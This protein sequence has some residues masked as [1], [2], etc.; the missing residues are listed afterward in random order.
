M[1]AVIQRVSEA[2]V[3]V[4]GEVVG[5]IGRG[6]CILLGICQ[7]DVDSDADYIIRKSLAGRFWPDDSG[8]KQ[9]AKCVKDIDGEILLVSQFTLYGTLSKGQKP[10]FHLAMK[11]DP[12][13]AFFDKIVDTFKQKYSASKIQSMQR[14][15][16][17]LNRSVD[18]ASRLAIY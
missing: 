14:L 8:A 3:V 4:D 12:A 11:T 6:L 16:F 15:R 2:K 13:R 5:Q 1:R 9:W 17:L 18:R 7:D 10:D